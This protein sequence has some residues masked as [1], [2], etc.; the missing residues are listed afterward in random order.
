MSFSAIHTR[1]IDRLCSF[2]PGHIN[3]RLFITVY[4]FL[5]FL[6]SGGVR[7]RRIPERQAAN[8]YAFFS[9]RGRSMS[10]EG[11][12]ED[13]NTYTD[14]TYGASTVQA[15]GCG[16]IAMRNALLDLCPGL[17]PAGRELPALIAA[18][19]KSGM[20]FGAR[21]GT[22]P[23]ALKRFMKKTGLETAAVC[24]ERDFETAAA[25]SDGLIM[26]MYNDR[27]DIRRQVHTVYVSKQIIRMPS[28]PAGSAARSGEPG[29]LYTA[30]NVYGDGR[31]TGPCES[32][33]ALMGQI[34]GG[35]A[36][37]ILLLTLRRPGTTSPAGK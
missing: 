6:P 34:R 15:A 7:R 5:R 25:A 12:I 4:S 33:E 16:L 18:F 24:R 30:H 17:P 2:L 23:A 28:G 1:L 9:H 20:V 27:N 29:F 36:R 21:F 8:E 32:F 26:L 35:R 10:G 13:Q 19:E 22:A 31:E 14:M 11:F 3:N 37:A